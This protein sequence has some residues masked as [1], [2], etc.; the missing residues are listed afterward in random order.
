MRYFGYF[1]TTHLVVQPHDHRPDLFVTLPKAADGQLDYTALRTWFASPDRRW[2]YVREKER[3]AILDK[4]ESHVVA[5]G[6]KYVVV[7]N[8]PLPETL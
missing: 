5:R 3:P 6:G 2:L 1:P 4:V 8:H 7:T